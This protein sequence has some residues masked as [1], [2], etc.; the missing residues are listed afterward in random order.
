MSRKTGLWPWSWLCAAL[1]C[2]RLSIILPAMG[3]LAA[4]LLFF[5]LFGSR[6]LLVLAVIAMVLWL[7]PRLAGH[8]RRR[9]FYR[10]QQ[11]NKANP[12]DFNARYQLGIIYRDARRYEQARRELEEAVAIYDGSSDAH[13]LLGDVY[14]RLGR[15]DDAVKAYAKALLLN[16]GHGYG[17]THLGMARAHHMAG[18]LEEARDWYQQTIM[19]NRSLAEPHYRLGCMHRAAGDKPAARA[20]FLAA[21][22]VARAPVRLGRTR[23]WWFGM[24]ARWQ[25][26]ALG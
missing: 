1:H 19:R 14:L 5:W 2:E 15:Y 9:R 8:I 20:A 25:L 10:E 6:V 7:A 21:A 4:W 18:R 12:R 17:A 11:A 22:E 23:N 13:A 26:L 24:L 16:P 3:T